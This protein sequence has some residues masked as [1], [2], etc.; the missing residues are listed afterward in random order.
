VIVTVENGGHEMSEERLRQFDEACRSHVAFVT[1]PLAG[2]VTMT[3]R[4]GTFIIPP[5]SY[6]HNMPLEE[7]EQFRVE[8]DDPMLKD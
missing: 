2:P 5:E 3:S 8:R 1:A 4:Y 6:K 7:L